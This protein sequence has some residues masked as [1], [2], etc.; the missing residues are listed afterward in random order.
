M[1]VPEAALTAAVDRDIPFAPV[2]SKPFLAVEFLALFV[3]IPLAL[4]LDK[5]IVPPIPL[6]WMVGIYCLVVLYRDP[7][8]PCA[9]LWNPR[10]LRRQVGPILL[11][12]TFGMA[13]MTWLTYT[14][15]PGRL[16]GFVRTHPVVWLLIM[17]LYPV[18]SVYPQ[19]IIYRAFLLH[20]YRHFSGTARQ[21]KWALILISALA[22]SLMHVV[23]KNWV[24]VVLTFAGG[25]LFARR[26]LETR[27]LFVSSFEHALYG[28]FVFS[29]GLGQYF[30]VR[31]V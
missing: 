30:Y 26:H 1:Q 24:A 22:F 19:G 11:L 15:P 9:Q 16:F 12:F 7:S 8:Y 14:L 10:A 29:I 31:L 6:L 2:R 20:R 13:A 3:A 23:F 25:I 5:P 18:L 28:C 21:R 27:S 17:V 4:A